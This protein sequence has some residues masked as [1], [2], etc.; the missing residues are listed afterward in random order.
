M[1]DKF[2]HKTFLSV[3]MVFLT[4]YSMAQQRT[5]TGRVTDSSDGN[6]LPGVN[7]SVK[8]SNL[9]TMTDGDGRFSIS[10]ADNTVLIFSFVGFTSQE[11]TVGA[12]NVID[13]QM[14]PDIRALSD[15]V[16]VGY[17]V[18]T[19]R[20][21]TGSISKV[22]GER[23][24]DMPVPSFEAALQGKAA[25][26]QVIQGSGMAG[27]GSVIRVRGIASLSA[28]GDPLYVVDGIP[29]TQD[30]F[31]N[32]ERGA[33][34]NN[35]LATINPNDIESVEILKD[36]SAAAIYGSRG[37]NGVILIT[38]KRG[39]KGKP[40]FNFSTRHGISQPARKLD[41]LNTNEWLQLYQEAWE[42]DGNTGRA[43]LPGGI[44]WEQAEQTNT[45][46][47][48]QTTR[49]GIKQEYNL[50]MTQGNDKL[51]S[52]VGLSYSDNQSFLVGNSYERL[53]GRVNLDY[54]ILPNLTATL[55]TSFSRG[56]N[57]RVFAA[58]SGGLGSA[59]SESLPF[60]P[61]RNPDGSY[62]TGGPNP[63]RQQE[64]LDWRTRENRTISNASI[65]YNPIEN[66]R[67]NGSAGVDYMDLIDDQFEP[68]EWTTTENIARRYP[69]WITNYTTSLTAAYDYKVNQDNKLTFLVGGEYQRSKTERYNSIVAFNV[70]APLYKNPDIPDRFDNEGNQ[71][72]NPIYT[73]APD[74][75]WAFLSYFGR[76][77]YS[78]KDRLYV[79]GSA[80]VDGSSRFGRNYRYG[81]FPSAGV[82]YVISEESFFPT[83][84]SVSFLKLKA[85]WGMTGNADIPNYQRFGTFFRQA[86]TD[87]NPY[88][89]EAILYP[90]RLENPNLKWEEQ[91][92]FDIGFELGLFDNRIVADFSY[93]DKNSTDVLIDRLVQPST[94][95]SRYF[96]NIAEI[97]NRGVELGLTSK[98]LTGA[99]K[100][101]TEI[102]ISRLRNKVMDVGPTPPDA[103]SGSG[104]TRVLPGLPVG[105][106]YLNRFAR[107]DPANGLPIFLDKEGNE[108][109]EFNLEDRVPVG[110]VVPDAVGGITNS[111]A[112][113]NFDFTV[114]F[115]FTIGG[116]IYDDAAKRQ[117]GIVSNW[118]MRRD[119]V[120]RWREP[121]DIAT[122]PRLTLEST[123]YGG[124][125]SF[126][127]LN[128]TQFLY[129]G[130]FLRLRN[131]TFGYN[132]PSQSLTKLKIQAARVFL[133]GSNLLTFTKFPGSDPEIVR[134]HNGPQ[135]RNLS[136][137][138]T[139]LT[140]PQE[141]S[142]TIGVNVQF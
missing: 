78:Y 6:S 119:I 35:P 63:V 13:V 140:P 82:G 74:Q 102:N 61:V 81:F 73:T 120:D 27:S 21:V 134:D 9:G 31:I 48:D 49:T 34:N 123:T 38:T 130:S 141:R 17:G 92:T 32:G 70:D 52:Y 91:R 28:G 4:L 142:I 106:N 30:P 60:Y 67:I 88:N 71:L 23:L 135:G 37:A 39:D 113:K 100:W 1:R 85:S 54:K 36:A 138:V 26:V 62:F 65:S 24:M 131:A 45:D 109:Y 47:Y 126:W 66:L 107:V 40:T 132:I 56:I 20:E 64:L 77:N 114:L 128:T 22:E 41:L 42:N 121:G 95:F 3:I 8:G 25:G 127:N 98:N 12:R 96:E 125:P 29:I 122:F 87:G 116:N 72:S 101:T 129:D 7:V 10:A 43:P 104:D 80:R 137:N 5:I 118:N 86:G 105:V 75:Y 139:Y 69:T 46:W 53:S 58:W 112:Y 124:L 57:N 33:F 108:T 97:N 103:I 99:F 18:Q 136:P 117:L 79:T 111:F 84:N 115:T 2:L 110:S 94:G 44:S 16:V 76:V 14:Q 90:I 50:S 15:I 11:I 59:M 51:T 133:S 19:K 83:T 93:F 55:N 89:G 68:A